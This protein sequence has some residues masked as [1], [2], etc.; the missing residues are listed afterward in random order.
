[1]PRTNSL[2]RHARISRQRSLF[3]ICLLFAPIAG[4]EKDSIEILFGGDTAFAKSYH[5]QYKRDGQPHILEEK[6]YEYTI[7]NLIPIMKRADHVILNLE[8][9]I[10]RLTKSEFESEKGYIHYEDPDVTQQLLKQYNVDAV[11]LANNHTLDL[12]EK[13]LAHTLEHLAKA[14]IALFGAGLTSKEAEEPYIRE[15]QAGGRK[16]QLAVIGAFEYREDYDQKFRFYA[17]SDKPGCNTLTVEK[18][19]QQILLIKEK[20][21]KAFVVVYPHW[22]KNYVWKN[23]TQTLMAHKLIDA[24]ADLIL[25]HGAHKIQE[26]E[27]Y[28]GKWIVYSLGNFL[29]NT[30]GRFKLL[31]A[32][33]YSM[34]AMLQ[35]NPLGNGQSAYLNLYPIFSDN[36]I[37]NFQPYFLSKPE[38][39]EF[40]KIMESKSPDLSFKL[41]RDKSMGEARYHIQL[42]IDL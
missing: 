30:L 19:S 2:L 3:C 24:G 21:P 8:T 13:G 9:P 39:K 25:G 5:D 12:A 22:G 36:Q 35:I 32:E 31:N 26:I 29:F 34:V 16:L 10:T 33:P 42:P 20:H 4:A 40:V 18:T 6:G 7:K 17:D 23:E 28:K 38:A 11:S 14:D 41:K 15:F 27:K 37:T 1:M